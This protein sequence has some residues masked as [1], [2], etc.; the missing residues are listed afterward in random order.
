MHNFYNIKFYL[1]L[2]TK[3]KTKNNK[4]LLK[5]KIIKDLLIN[6][7]FFI[8]FKVISIKV[9][10]GIKQICIPTYIDYIMISFIKKILEEV[11]ENIFL[12]HNYAF[13]I[14]ENIFG[15]FENVHT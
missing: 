8:S 1:K 14:H 7:F 10:F 9:Y 13:R 5:K 12:T 3:F 11:L 2:I 15:L 6:N 4:F